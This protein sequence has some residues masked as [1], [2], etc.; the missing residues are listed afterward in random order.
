[1]ALRPVDSILGKLW[2]IPPRA[3]SPF[4][5]QPGEQ[6]PGSSQ[7]GRSDP[8]GISRSQLSFPSRL[9]RPG[10][11]LKGTALLDKAV[12]ERGEI[13]REGG[14][15]VG[16]EEV[17]KGKQ[18][19]EGERERRRERWA[20]AGTSNLPVPLALGGK[21]EHGWVQ[22]SPVTWAAATPSTCCP[23]NIV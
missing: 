8:P 22:C 23:E 2:A 19:R 9:L 1:M 20:G 3:C 12:Q 15:K 10:A 17:R 11:A 13:G 5:C 14:A 18:G 16:D 21:Q 6:V 7:E 4:L